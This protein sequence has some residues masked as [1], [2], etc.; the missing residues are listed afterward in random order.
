MLFFV[1]IVLFLNVRWDDLEGDL[2]KFRI[3]HWGSEEKIFQV[4]C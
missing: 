4:A 2:H 1:E 3:P